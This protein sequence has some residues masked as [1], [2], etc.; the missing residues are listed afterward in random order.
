MDAVKMKHDRLLQW[1]PLTYY[2]VIFFFF[3]VWRG[4]RFSRARDVT[5]V[6]GNKKN[7]IP[8]P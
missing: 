6:T 8:S 4:Y 3:P 1:V 5:A 2:L 7:P